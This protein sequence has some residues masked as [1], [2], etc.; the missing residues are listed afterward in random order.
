MPPTLDKTAVMPDEDFRRSETSSSLPVQSYG[1]ADVAVPIEPHS[2]HHAESQIKAPV[3][4]EPVQ[5][6]VYH[7]VQ[8]GHTLWRIARAYEVAPASIATANGLPSIETPLEI[9]EV[10]RIPVTDTMVYPPREIIAP[11]SS[12]AQV[13]QVTPSTKAH[14]NDDL[15]PETSLSKIPS[16]ISDSQHNNN[17]PSQVSSIALDDDK[18]ALM[19]SSEGFSELL[20]PGQLSRRVSPESSLDT[21]ALR[22]SAPVESAEAPELDRDEPLATP[23]GQDD[24]ESSLLAVAPEIRLNRSFIQRERQV[25]ETLESHEVR[26]G[27]TLISLANQ[28]QT[29]IEEIARVNGLDDPNQITAGQRLEIPKQIARRSAPVEVFGEDRTLASVTDKKRRLDA[30]AAIVEDNPLEVALSTLDE[31]RVSRLDADS[32]VPEISAVPEM[33]AEADIDE[34]P[35]IAAAKPEP[36][37]VSTTDL[38]REEL[39]SE[40]DEVEPSEMAIPPVSETLTADIAR[41]RDRVRRNDVRRPRP[42]SSPEPSSTDE[43]T[44]HVDASDRSLGVVREHSNPQFDRDQIALA[45]RSERDEARRSPEES[46]ESDLASAN[47]SSSASADDDQVA[48]APLG[49]HNYAPL[50]EP[51][52]VSPELPGLPSSGAY[53]PKPEERRQAFDG[54][55]WPAQGVFTSGYGWRW[56]RMHRGIDIAGPVGTPIVAAA[57]GTVTYSR[58]NS[59][60]FGNLVEI[61]HPDGSLTLYAHNHRNLV[62][63]G[64]E[65]SQGQQIAEMGSTGFSTGPHVHFEIHRPGQGPTDP[66]AFLPR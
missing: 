3:A 44:L 27:E 65:V 66:M 40:I 38:A 55:I 41:L 33:A 54:Y 12:E 7:V 10:L 13:A 23:S 1:R 62:S 18:L 47:V 61:T 49:S 52:S 2:Q 32:D 31:E 5:E 9:G 53:L 51:R 57:P 39:A 64:E 29:T 4:Q 43:L 26:Q 63:E 58:W 35:V 30:N 36:P 60:G 25:L 24:R 11:D 37:D 22:S 59:G 19:D 21:T 56:G 34:I 16:S 45:R 46:S 48:V 42:V 8:S 28:H 50:M 20:L 17:A 14:A 6:H 15:T